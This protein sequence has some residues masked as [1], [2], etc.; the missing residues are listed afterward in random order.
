MNDSGA[1]FCAY[2]CSGSQ[3]WQLISR[4]VQQRSSGWLPSLTS[5]E[6]MCVF[7][8]NIF[9]FLACCLVLCNQETLGVSGQIDGLLPGLSLGGE[10]A[11]H[12]TAFLKCADRY[13]KVYKNQVK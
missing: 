5:V 9:R 8:T 7:H 11:V 12:A 1:S 2:A 6:F 4:R 3:I 13:E 10:I